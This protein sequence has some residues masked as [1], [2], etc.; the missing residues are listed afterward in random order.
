MIPELLKWLIAF[1]LCLVLQTTLIPHTAIFGIQP[2]LLIIVLALFCFDYGVLAGV[3]VGFFFGLSLDTY[4]P[5][6]LGQHALAKTVF[7]AFIGVFNERVMRTDPIF[8][9]SIIVVGIIIHDMLFSGVELAKNGA[10]LVAL[11]P[12]LFFR[13]LPRAIYSIAIIM[14]IQVWQTFIKPNIRI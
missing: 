5:S 9:I 1:I 10:S 13:T 8:K 3:F 11:V 2:D 4:S 6:F 12:E 14:I 7:G